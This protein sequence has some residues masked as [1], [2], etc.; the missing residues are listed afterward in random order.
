[1]Y[2]EHAPQDRTGCGEGEGEGEGTRLRAANDGDLA[3]G[4]FLDE[5]RARKVVFD[6]GKYT[7][8]TGTHEDE[9]EGYE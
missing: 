4:G 5:P 9:E 2:E 1:M 8:V 3:V 6:G 7:P